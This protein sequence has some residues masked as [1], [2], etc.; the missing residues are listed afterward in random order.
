MTVT[1]SVTST[2]YMILMVQLSSI[3][4]R[5]SLFLNFF[6]PFLLMPNFR[7]F[8][9]AVLVLLLFL[10]LYTCS[11]IFSLDCSKTWHAVIPLFWEGA[12]GRDKIAPPSKI[13]PNGPF[14]LN[15][16]SYVTF[17]LFVSTKK[18]GLMP[19]F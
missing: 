12:G 18:I 13:S 9:V 3:N 14:E 7:R 8:H 19:T 5:K 11:P 4:K 10:A 2:R 17:K 1:V 16:G 15:L 6:R